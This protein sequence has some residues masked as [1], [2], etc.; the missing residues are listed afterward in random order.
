MGTSMSESR[1]KYE[2]SLARASRALWLAADQAERI[3][4]TGAVEDCV[5][6]RREVARLMEDSIKGKRR[7]RRQ[8][9][10][11]DLGGIG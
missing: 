2:A 4:D 3:Q 5:A 1:S 7:K 8:L 6:I 11:S 9:D 10:L